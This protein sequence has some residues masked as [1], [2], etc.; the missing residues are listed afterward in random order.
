[1]ARVCFHLPYLSRGETRHLCAKQTLEQQAAA[2]LLPPLQ[3]TTFG[4]RS[5][6]RSSV[7]FQDNDGDAHAYFHA[8]A[9]VHVT[10]TVILETHRLGR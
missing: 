5:L 7:A 8:R 1:M 2:G 4:D 9:H 6:L 3:K 10:L